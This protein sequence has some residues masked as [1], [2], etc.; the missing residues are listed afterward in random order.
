MKKLF[1]ILVLVL[2]ILSCKKEKDKLS[3]T[4]QGDC[5]N[6]SFKIGNETGPVSMNI[7]STYTY[8]SYG[9][10]SQITGSGT[11]TYQNSGKTYQVQQVVNNLTCKYKITVNGESSCGN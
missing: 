5:N 3:V 4:C 1:I 11:Y 6:Y 9:R 8:D 2:S 10:V 7:T